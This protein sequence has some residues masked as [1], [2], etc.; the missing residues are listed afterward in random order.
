MPLAR[1]SID[2][3][4]TIQSPN[5]ASGTPMT[6]MVC[7]KCDASIEQPQTFEDHMAREHP[8]VPASLGFGHTLT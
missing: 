6:K 4:A 3:P 7:P 8:G 1:T 5:Y 2:G